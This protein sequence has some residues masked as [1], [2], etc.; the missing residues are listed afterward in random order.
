M[1]I[2]RIYRTMSCQSGLLHVSITESAENFFNLRCK[3]GVSRSN[4]RSV[5]KAVAQCLGFKLFEVLVFVELHSV[6][7]SFSWV[8][9]D[10][11]LLVSR[12]TVYRN[13][14]IFITLDYL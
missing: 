8:G 5:E 2:L 9:Q 4:D 14:S 7:F 10:A 3:Q 1:Y 13:T 6:Q 11:K 12:I